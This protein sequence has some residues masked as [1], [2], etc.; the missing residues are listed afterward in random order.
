MLLRP[1]LLLKSLIYLGYKELYGIEYVLLTGHKIA[2][3]YSE[4]TACVEHR[5]YTVHRDYS[6]N[7]GNAVHKAILP[8]A[9]VVEKSSPTT[10]EVT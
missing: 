9:L 5:V 8:I 7:E 4:S 2:S 10:P 6:S 1:Y 3:G